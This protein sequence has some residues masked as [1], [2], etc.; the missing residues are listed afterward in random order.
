[1]LAT[2]GGDSGHEMGPSAY[3]QFSALGFSENQPTTKRISKQTV[4]GSVRRESQI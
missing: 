4:P 1:M 2:V 3:S